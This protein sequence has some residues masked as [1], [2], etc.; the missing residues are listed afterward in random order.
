[1]E[2]E[3]KRPRENAMLERKIEKPYKRI[4]KGCGRK[5]FDEHE[6]ICIECGATTKEVE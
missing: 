4:C 1:M 5:T 3:E 6:T 2:T